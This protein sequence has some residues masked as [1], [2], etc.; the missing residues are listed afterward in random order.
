MRLVISQLEETAGLIIFS[1]EGR[2]L[3]EDPPEAWAIEK[4]RT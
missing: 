2:A 4:E 1:S 3:T